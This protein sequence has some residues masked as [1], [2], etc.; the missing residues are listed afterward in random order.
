MRLLAVTLATAAWGQN[1]SDI[2]VEK[3]SAGHVFTEG[4]AWSRE[5]YLV[6]S[7]VP[8][9]KIWK[10]TP[11]QKPAVFREESGGANGNAFDARG[12]LY[13]CETRGRRVIRTDMKTNRVDV[14]C[15][16]WDGKKLNAPNDIVV[17]KD[18][19]V[20]FTDPAFGKQ[21]DGRELDFYGVYHIPP[22]GPAELVA[23]HKGRPNGVA[24]S[25]NGKTLY[26]SNSDER[27]VYA[28]DLDGK[29]A[30]SGER[31]FLSKIDGPPDGIR[32][33]E[34]G[35]I[36]VA[37][38]GV[39]IYSPE[40]NLIHTIEVAET[41]RNIAFGDPDLQTLYITALTSIYRVRLDVKGAAQY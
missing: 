21:A 23:R 4:P 26:V 17:R 8:A 30:A 10:W 2:K 15:D 35:N 14:L 1:F 31:V 7:D 40:G 37:A 39:A 20:Y 41:P 12:N 25:P 16:N 9:N 22:K 18:G 19:H 33:D 27:A 28:Y 24:L 5:G 11:G 32:C 13:T 34:K 36:Y 6:W 38:R 3:F 29:G